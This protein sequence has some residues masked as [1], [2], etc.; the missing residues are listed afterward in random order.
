M[1]KS[2]HIVRAVDAEL[3]QLDNMIAEMGGLAERQLENAIAALVGRDREMAETIIE[4][5]EKIDHLEAQ[6]N[7]FVIRFLALRQPVADDLRVIIAAL[8][9]ATYIERI[10]DYAKNLAK[11]TLAL[12]ESRVVHGTAASIARMATVVQAMIA[13]ALGAYIARDIAQADDVRRRDTEVDQLN[14]SMFRELLTY[15]LEDPRHISA[16][17]HLLFAAKNLERMGD[18]AT[19]IAEQV[20]FI[21]TGSAPKD[22]RLKQDESSTTVLA[23]QD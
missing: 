14:S 12:E 22:E 16:C 4:G 17:T 19:G 1:S 2:E 6:V 21:V 23:A 7:A 18:H 13:G 8:K 20:H 11:R 3:G 5:D 10:G 9:I 15:M